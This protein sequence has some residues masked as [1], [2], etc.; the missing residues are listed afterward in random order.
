[1]NHK[2]ELVNQ[3]TSGVRWQSSVEY[4]IGN[5]VT[6]FIEI[7]PGRVLTGLIKRIDRN[8]RLININSLE[9]IK[10]IKRLILG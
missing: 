7:G 4:M 2:E 10:D 9:S 5:G 1:M 6:T 8:V 3:L